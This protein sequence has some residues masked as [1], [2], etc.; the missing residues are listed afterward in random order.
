[1][2]KISVIVPVYNSEKY[3]EK[4]LKSILIQKNVEFEIIVVNDGSTDNS[5]KI[6]NEFVNIY[7]NKIKYFYKENGGLSDARNYGIKH[8]TGDYIC[9]VDS[10]DYLDE[11]LFESLE[12]YINKDIELIKYKCVKVD[13]NYKELEKV[14]GPI[15]ENKS[16]EDAFNTLYSSDVLIEPACLYLYKKDFWVKNN[17]SFPLKKYHE[18]WAVVPY[19]LISAQ[20][21]A[22]VNLY[23]ILLCSI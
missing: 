17:F 22:S 6:I 3:I 11:T 16:G 5:E 10:D 23:R 15:F 9:F 2:H 19:I 8:I 21:V 14:D 1:M 20:S 7:P 18:D 12:K 13:S 4:C